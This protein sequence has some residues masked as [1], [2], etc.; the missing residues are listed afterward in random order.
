MQFDTKYLFSLYTR[1]QLEYWNQGFLFYY[2]D[3]E[4]S[5]QADFCNG[6]YRFF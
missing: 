1:G 5:Q 6:L 2:G 3:V 4:T